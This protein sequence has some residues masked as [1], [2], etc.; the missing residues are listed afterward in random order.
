MRPGP[1]PAQ[2]GTTLPAQMGQAFAC[3][4]CRQPGEVFAPFRAGTREEPF[5]V[6]Q[7]GQSLDGRVA[8]FA[9]DSRDINRGEA[10]DHLHRIRAEVDAVVVGVGTVVADDPML[11]VRR[12]PGRNPARVVIDPHGRLPRDARVLNRDGSRRLVVCAA[13]ADAPDGAE[14]VPLRRDGRM[15]RPRD[16][17]EALGRLGFRSILVEGGGRTISAFM[18]AGCIDRLH[19]LVAPLLLGS[20]KASLDLKPVALLAHATRPVTQAYAL[21]DGEVLF[22]CD[23][24]GASLSA[25]Q[26]EQVGMPDLA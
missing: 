21:A 18:D 12:V 1:E 23:L 11:T 7:I 14:A 8:T 20:G 26:G 3:I 22:D 6:A 24:R 15:F 25:G 17:V 16:I 9:G 19:V 2:H 5:V 10:L 4:R 13:G